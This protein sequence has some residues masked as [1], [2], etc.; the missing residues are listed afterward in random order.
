MEEILKDSVSAMDG[1]S[2]ISMPS[3]ESLPPSP[4]K[5]SHVT[6]V[7]LGQ[8]ELE[9]LNVELA[10]YK[11]QLKT[12]VEIYEMEKNSN[13]AQASILSSMHKQAQK[14]AADRN[15]LEAELLAM[16]RQWEQRTEKDAF[17]RSQIN[18]LRLQVQKFH[19]DFN[20]EMWSARKRIRDLPTQWEPIIKESMQAYFDKTLLPSIRDQQKELEECR[21]KLST[22]ERTSAE[23]KKAMAEFEM[24]WKRERLLNSTLLERIEVYKQMEQRGRQRWMPDG[25]ASACTSC[26]SE[27]TLV[28]RKVHCFRGDF[29]IP[30]T[31]GRFS[32]YM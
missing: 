21:S 31:A 18:Q 5:G 32:Y 22:L 29:P 9:M 6:M 14:H 12:Q 8:E 13:D 20:E 19:C 23:Q 15:A 3:M 1:I 24:Q 17:Y 7:E 4:R 2:M 27:F 10:S 11:Q 30:H 26:G 28:N 16:R 25:F